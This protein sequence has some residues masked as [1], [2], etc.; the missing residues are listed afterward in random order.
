[1]PRKSKTSPIEDLI[2]VIAWFP[3]WVGVAFALLSYLLLHY[4][5]TAQSRPLR[6]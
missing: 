4:F 6:M 2:E 3:W 5:A 1:M